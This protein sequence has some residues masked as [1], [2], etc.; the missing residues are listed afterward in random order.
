MREKQAPVPHFPWAPRATEQT[1][2][3]ALETYMLEI[4]LDMSRVLP[5]Q[6]SPSISSLFKVAFQIKKK[7]VV[8]VSFFILLLSLQPT[9]IFSQQLALSSPGLHRDREEKQLPEPQYFRI[10]QDKFQAGGSFIKKHKNQVVALHTLEADA[11]RWWEVTAG[12]SSYSLH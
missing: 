6:L 11:I 2:S 5:T 3:S 1:C 12:L 7:I 10:L 9:H 8:L 4:S